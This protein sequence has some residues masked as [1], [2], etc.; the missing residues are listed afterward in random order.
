MLSAKWRRSRR[1]R[2]GEGGA[3]SMGQIRAGAPSV[4]HPRPLR[5]PTT[6]RKG[7]QRGSG[8]G[9]GPPRQWSPRH[10][11]C[12]REDDNGV[13]SRGGA[14]GCAHLVSQQPV[15]NEHTVQPVAQ[16]LVHQGGRHGGVHA[17]RQRADGVLVGADL[18]TG[19]VGVVG[20][21]VGM[22]RS[23]QGVGKR[24]VTRG[25]E[26][27]AGGRI[28]G[29]GRTLAARAAKGQG[30][31]GPPT[32]PLPWAARG[33]ARLKPLPPRTQKCLR[34]ARRPRSSP[35][36]ATA[37]H[38]LR[39]NLELGLQHLRHG[40]VSLE[41]RDLCDIII[42]FFWGGVPGWFLWA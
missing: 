42:V 18:G 34:R 17:P 2:G 24:E 10:Q 15:V 29:D 20:G 23:G 16:H 30:A 35:A 28:A 6:K 7:L 38:L 11:V 36:N 19:G 22:G 26:E 39:D 40:P 12:N 8:S 14:R 4:E 32:S 37:P 31:P 5:R 33:E 13:A 3:R 41:A 1:L 9:A 27:R 21:L 25:A